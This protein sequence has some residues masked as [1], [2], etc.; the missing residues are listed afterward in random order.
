MR[1]RAHAAVLLALLALVAAGL[2][3]TAPV[4]AGLAAQVPTGSVPTVTGSPSGPYIVVN[5]GPDP[6]IN[7]RALPNRL[8]TQIG[9]LLA[10]QKVPAMGKFDDWILIAY[11]GVPGG[12]GWV[13]SALV[14][15]YGELPLVEPPPTP[16]PLVT[17]TI[18]PTLAAQFI[19]TAAPT[20]LPTFTPQAP[21]VVPTLPS[22]EPGG[23]AARVPMGLIIVGLG[24]LGILLGFVSLIRGK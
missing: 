23:V 12:E 2:A 5:S 1:T 6:Q 4:Q 16:T 20:R 3:W 17:A 9:V 18:D 24:S 15:V 19:I 10:G 14:Q 21:L 8:S 11:P 13:Y 22:A 7:V